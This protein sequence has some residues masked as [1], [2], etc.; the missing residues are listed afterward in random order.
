MKRP[1]AGKKAVVTAAQMAL[2]SGVLSAVLSGCGTPGAPMPPSLGLPQTVGDLSAARVGDRVTLHWTMPRRNTDKLLLKGNVSARV[3]RRSGNS[4][5]EMAGGDLAIAPGSEGNFTETLPAAL[6]SGTPRLVTYFVELKSSRGR[7]AGLSNGATILAGGAP[8]PVEGLTASVNRR[9]VVLHWKGGTET[10]SIRLERTLLSAPAPRA[11]NTLPGTPAEPVLQKLSLDPEEAAGHSAVDTSAHFGESYR[12]RVQRV[13]R[14]VVD[15]KLVELAGEFSEPVRVD[16][17]KEF[18][19]AVPTGL[20]AV[21]VAGESGNFMDLNWQ[22]VTESGLAGYLLYRSEDNGAWEKLTEKPI[23]TPFFRDGAVRSG[24]S[25]RY[26][27]CSVGQSGH[28]SARSEEA[29]E[30]VP[31]P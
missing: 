27:V 8:A 12:Y 6:V 1:F 7:S 10:T 2:L 18:P 23:A 24:H 22:P 28:V 17:L 25:Y 16:V 31:E 11:K 5:C 26:A 29:A 13:A 30:S 14:Q 21:A 3:C 15:G 20:A 9:G 4:A 19:P